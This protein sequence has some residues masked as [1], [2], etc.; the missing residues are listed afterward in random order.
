MPWKKTCAMCER[1]L[2]ID[3]CRGGELTVAEL[4]RA[5]GI[6]RQV[7]LGTKNVPDG[8]SIWCHRSRLRGRCPDRGASGKA[9]V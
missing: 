9:R 6:S 5:F 1:E 2:F 4:C 7:A 3:H 8:V